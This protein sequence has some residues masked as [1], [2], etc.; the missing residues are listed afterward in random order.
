MRAA[1]AILAVSLLGAVV[2][3]ACGDGDSNGGGNGTIDRVPTVGALQEQPQP[4]QALDEEATEPEDGVLEV[5]IEGAIFL[6]NRLSA[7]VGQGVTIRVTNNDGQPHNLRLAGLDGQYDTED[8][9]VTQPAT[10]EGQGAGELN[11]SP[12]VPGAYTFRCDFHPGSMGGQIIAE[13][14]SG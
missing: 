12:P 6:H 5:Q 4:V 13:G 3:A 8:D 2:L 10:I 11:F 14:G 1:L 9:A 7:P